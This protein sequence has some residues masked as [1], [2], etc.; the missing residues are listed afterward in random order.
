MLSAKIAGD[1]N[2]L[3]VVLDGLSAKPAAIKYG[4]ARVLLEH[5]KTHPEDIYP[6]VQIFIDMLA[7]EN[8][9]VQAEGTLV[10]SHLAVVDTDG[11]IDDIIERYLAPIPGP[12]LMAAANAIKGAAKIVTARP[13]LA[14]WVATEILKVEKA[15]Y[16]TEE[17]RNIAL[18]QAVLTFDCIFDLVT[19]KKALLTFMRRQLDN[20][21]SATRKKAEKALKKRQSA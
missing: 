19:D 5:S 10:L 6:H 20:P 14:D 18:G 7:D 2:A 9:I 11:R 13:H 3:S 21:R 4:C 15:V 1:S 17:C 8:K 12:T 16:K